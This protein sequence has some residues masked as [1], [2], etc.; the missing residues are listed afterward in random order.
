MTAMHHKTALQYCYDNYI[1]KD[2]SDIRVVMNSYII[3][4]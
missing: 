2:L 3:H 4:F 1:S